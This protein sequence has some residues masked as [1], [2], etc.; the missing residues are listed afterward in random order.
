MKKMYACAIALLVSFNSVANIK[1][2]DEKDVNKDLNWMRCSLIEVGGH[3]YVVFSHKECI[4][5]QHHAGCKACTPNPPVVMYQ[6]NPSVETDVRTTV[7]CRLAFG[8]SDN[9]GGS[10]VSSFTIRNYTL[11]ELKRASDGWDSH[12]DK[13]TPSR[14]AFHITK[15]VGC[16]QSVDEKEVSYEE[17]LKKIR[18]QKRNISDEEW[19]RTVIKNLE[20]FPSVI[21]V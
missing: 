18:P 11:D 20:K 12:F 13:H 2:I 5:S 16:M 8:F 7:T 1:V 9:T 6:A 17:F 15:S 4:H 21:P 3:E 14:I 19:R 10:G